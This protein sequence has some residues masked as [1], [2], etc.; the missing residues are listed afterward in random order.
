MKKTIASVVLGA[1]TTLTT[2]SAEP[3]P[4][5]SKSIQTGILKYSK[6]IPQCSVVKGSMVQN[7]LQRLDYG[8]GKIE[9]TYAFTPDGKELE[10]ITLSAQ[11]SPKDNG[12]LHA[13]MCATAAFVQAMQPEF[14]TQ[15]SALSTASH[16]WKSSAKAPF[17]M[18]FYFEKL[19]AQHV[20]FRLV[21]WKE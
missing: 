9:V 17:T 16:L 8:V 13:M 15:D 12:Q 1:A 14:E 2:V 6:Q 20:P 11:G 7:V 19:K 10:S 3:L 4:Q 5:K 18:A 21:A